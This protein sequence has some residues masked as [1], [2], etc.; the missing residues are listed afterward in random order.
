MQMMIH[1]T[2]NMKTK[3]TMRNGGKSFNI[4]VHLL[5]TIKK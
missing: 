4:V 3:L 2:Q 1:K 5:E